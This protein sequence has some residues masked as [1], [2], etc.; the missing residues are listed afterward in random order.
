MMY[1]KL[2]KNGV[3]VERASVLDITYCDEMFEVAITDKSY[4]T[5]HVIGAYGKR[6]TLDI[7]LSRKFMSV[8]LSRI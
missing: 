1:N 6:S 2:I 5:P 4:R 3:T 8:L 7:T